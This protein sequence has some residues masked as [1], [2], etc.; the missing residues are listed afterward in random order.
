MTTESPKSKL[1][2]AN[3]TPWEYEFQTPLPPHAPNAKS[4]L[5]WRKVSQGVIAELNAAR[6]PIYLWGNPGCGK[7][8]I[9]GL[10]YMGA[11]GRPIWINAIEGM[12]AVATSCVDPQP[13]WGFGLVPLREREHWD[14][15]GERALVV[16][17]DIAL[18]DR[19]SDAQFEVMQKFLTVRQNRP[20]I[21]TGNLSIGKVA[22]VYDD[23]VASR[24]AAGTAIEIT[25]PDMRL[26]QRTTCKS[27][28][29]NDKVKSGTTTPFA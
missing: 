14:E 26:E 11:T 9:A 8:S 17:D 4:A 27:T 24:L 13:L 18:R 15:L 6:F 22:K 29:L 20:T 2:K 25:G 3:T 1:Q 23:R 12:R 21:I 19:A 5:T 10:I 16:L 28:P 7:S